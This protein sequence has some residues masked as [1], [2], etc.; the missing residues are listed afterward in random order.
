MRQKVANQNA[1]KNFILY[2]GHT[3]WK[4]KT[5]LFGT[6][7]V[8]LS[9][10][11]IAE[12]TGTVDVHAATGD[13][14]VTDTSSS[15]APEMSGSAKLNSD[16]TGGTTPTGTAPT[17]SVPAT[18]SYSPASIS[19]ESADISAR[20]VAASATAD[21]AT[22]P[23][24]YQTLTPDQSMSVGKTD[25]SSVTLSGSQVQDHFTDTVR[26]YNSK[27]DTSPQATE[28]NTLS[29]AANEQGVWQLTNNGS[30][31]YVSVTSTGDTFKSTATGP[32][33][34]HVSFEHEIDFG[35]NFSM[36]GALGIGSKADG[37]ADGVGIVFAPGDPS[38]ATQGK[39]GGNLGVGGLKN[40]FAFVYDDIHNDGSDDSK[41]VDPGTGAYFGWR[42]T[43]A[44]GVMQNVT[45]S[46]DWKAASGLTLNRATDNSL[47]N[48]TMTYDAMLKKLSVTIAGQ[49][50][51]RTLTNI[52]TKQGYSI[53]I[54][55]STGSQTNDYSA[56]IDSF[57]YTP[58]TATVSVN[59]AD[60]TAGDTPVSTTTPVTANIGD[61]ISVFS[62]K[63]AAERAV[64]ADP[65]LDPSLVT[66]IPASTTSNV[67]V[68]DGDQATASN[69]TVHYSG[70]KSLADAAYY[71]YKVTGD[72]YPSI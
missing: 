30:H 57:T 36:T 60:A 54:A 69:G 15:S 4:I 23:K 53:S 22:S 10:V 48:F 50:F 33:T 18:Q 13:A 38:Y 34:A 12:S 46:T 68:V 44:N 19:T 71:S 28:L 37:G 45:S 16:K 56:R 61:T 72:G 47:N 26:N 31:P 43:D 29:S 66:V 52:D 62:T 65:T 59:V 64:A 40:A 17:N 27:G 9:A 20:E 70:D 1:K 58:K 11:A 8:G 24:Q 2:K 21:A 6:L 25:G 42:S 35:H 55:A 41:V 51:E 49:T 14:P 32:Q 5:R 67:Y 63:E 39:T 7:L 3:G